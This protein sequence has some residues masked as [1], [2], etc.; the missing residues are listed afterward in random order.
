MKNRTFAWPSGNYRSNRMRCASV[1][2][3]YIVVSLSLL[4]IV[5][6]T[7]LSLTMAQT[8]IPSQGIQPSVFLI[9]EISV[10]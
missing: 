9:F 5:T 7:S 8:T 10:I 4:Q 6:P 2:L 1:Q 3:F